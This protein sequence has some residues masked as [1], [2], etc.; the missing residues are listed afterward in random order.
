MGT[1]ELSTMHHSDDGRKQFPTAGK[2]CGRKKREKKKT[3]SS[4]TGCKGREG[5][6]SRSTK[7]M[8]R[9][10]GKRKKNKKRGIYLI[11]TPPPPRS[12]HRRPGRQS[13]QLPA[14]PLRPSIISLPQFQSLIHVVYLPQLP[15]NAQARNTTFFI[16][17]CLHVCMSCKHMDLSG[18]I[19]PHWGLNPT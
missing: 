16:L 4:P 9:E 6:A 8:K 10:I 18:A 1:N 17:V 3:T 2:G 7:Y 13:S 15:S 19:A 12:N 11:N 5:E 14:D